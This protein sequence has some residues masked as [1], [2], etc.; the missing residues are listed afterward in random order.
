MSVSSILLEIL[1]SAPPLAI[2]PLNT[3]LTKF[4]SDST[5]NFA[6]SASLTSVAVNSLGTFVSILNPDALFF[7]KKSV[8]RTS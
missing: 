5:S 3:L 1:A 2:T 6:S 7:S 4:F 8:R